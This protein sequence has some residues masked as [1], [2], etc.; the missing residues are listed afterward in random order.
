MAMIGICL[1]GFLRLISHV[2]QAKAITKLAICIV[3]ASATA[4]KTILSWLYS[5]AQQVGRDEAKV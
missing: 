2:S 4:A 3:V 5:L 1:F